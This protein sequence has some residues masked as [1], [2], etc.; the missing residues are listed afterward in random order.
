MNM[1]AQQRCLR[2][3][4]PL[5]GILFCLSCNES[6][7][8]GDGPPL[9]TANKVKVKSSVK[10]SGKKEK[11]IR[12]ELSDL[13]RPHLN[14]KTLGVRLKLWIYNISG[15]PK[16]NKGF[17]HWLKYK[18]GEEPVLASPNLIEKNRQI[19]QNHLENKGYFRDTVMVSTTVKNKKLT[20]VYTAEIGD[21]Y[22]IRNVTYPKDTDSL[23]LRIDSLQRR[24]L[25]KKG[26][27]YDLDLIKEE[28]T[29]IDSRLKNRGF[30]YFNPDYLL[31]DLD[32]AVG[33]HQV[34]MHL[35]IKEEI[36]QEA[37]NVYRINDVT[38][39]AEYDIRRDSSMKNAYTT[40]EGFKILDTL[41]YLRPIVFSKTLV[42]KPG[43]IYKRDDHNL[44]LSRLVSLGVF[45]FVKARFEPVDTTDENSKLNAF[46][47]LTPTAKKSIRF[48]V[49]GLTRSDNTTGGEM[50]V[51]WRNRNFFHGAELFNAKFYGG[52][53]EQ[54]I[55]LGQKI[56]TRRYG[57]GLDLYI[58]RIIS[59]FKLN[60][61]SAFVPKTRISAGYDIFD[62]S[63]EYTLN[64]ARASFGYI[65][66]NTLT[67]E[68]QLTVLGIN[69]VRPTNIDSAF[70]VGLDSNITL[71]RSIERQFIIGSSY[72]FNYNSQARPNHRMNNFYF[73]GN[74]D[75][76]GNALG[77]I[78]G[79]NLN[80]GKQVNIFNV[81]FAQYIRL[82]ADFRHYLSFNKYS[83]LASRITGGAGFSY[84]NS[85][86]M[87]FIKEFFAG[88][89]NDLRAFRSRALGP[90]S[91]FAG[92]PNSV[93]I[94]ADQ[95]GD[96]KLEMN[97]EY[98]AKLFSIVRWAIFMDAGN[99]WTLRSDTS[100]PGSQF[101][102]HFL[103]DIAVG[104]G[105]G[106]R[107]D[108]TIL[109]LRLDV[110]VPVRY[111]WLPDGS[112][113]VLKNTTDISKMVLNLAIGYPF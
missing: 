91:Y 10:I 86:T 7:Y 67:T 48:E 37:R 35:L 28:R 90:G 9:W 70:Q 51:N 50:S 68:N 109:V 8:L 87:P 88:G 74:L 72:N 13:L 71:R 17:K 14:G 38:V 103:K 52:L 66:K 45:K 92:N 111:P 33:N 85:T 78:T 1:T 79:A 32:T 108:L 27:P 81:P 84:G 31:V 58:P 26:A 30:Y 36:P 43:D 19:L 25:L 83:M 89:T 22:T 47:Y 82:E 46:Y 53:E 77:L 3:F 55:G 100:R 65:F 104:V 106:L 29:R 101:D 56:S 73:N 4:I 54:F 99:V 44:S 105:T 96:V 57:V 41:H 98:R 69:Y 94:L 2:Y 24:S 93:P 61:S 107:F 39:Y 15:H 18:V 20:A 97:L 60:T 21:Q 75:L 80:K 102:N 11:N 23:G 42:F 95:P 76:S 40:P 5:F 49:S 34:D 113:W 16:K 110:A 112:K 6:K 12:S 63:A 62:R 59:P 64:S